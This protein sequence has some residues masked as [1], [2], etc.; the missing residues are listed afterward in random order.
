MFGVSGSDG[1]LVVVV[2]AERKT[3]S[4]RKSRNTVSLH[5]SGLRA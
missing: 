3:K 1:D 2:N 4:R 5:E